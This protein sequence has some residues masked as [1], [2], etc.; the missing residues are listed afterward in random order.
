MARRLWSVFQEFLAT[1]IG[2]FFS[3]DEAEGMPR[4][5][6]LRY[7]G[8]LQTIALLTIIALLIWPLAA[9]HPPA[10]PAVEGLLL[11]V[12]AYVVLYALIPRLQA[13]PHRTLIHV[14]LA[15]LAIFGLHFALLRVGYGL[16]ARDPHA[17][18]LA[19]LVPL[20]MISRHGQTR[21]W[22]LTLILVVVLFLAF[23]F[24]AAGADLDQP[25][26]NPFAYA[27]LW[28]ELPL[29]ITYRQLLLITLFAAVYHA[30]VREMHHYQNRIAIEYEMTDLLTAQPAFSATFQ[31]AVNAI[32]NLRRPASDYAF[33]LLRHGQTDQLKVVGVAGLPLQGW[34][35][36]ALQ[37]GT[38]ITG[39]AL[40][41]GRTIR[42]GDVHHDDYREIFFGPGPL[43]HVRS[44]MATP[45]IVNGH[46]IGV[47]DVESLRPNAYTLQHAAKL[48][49]WAK[50]MANTYKHFHAID[51]QVAAANRLF[52]RIIQL[53]HEYSRRPT[54]GGRVSYRAWF[55]AV[56][57]EIAAHFHAD[58]AALLRLG[59]GT[60]HPLPPP[61]F[62]SRGELPPLP[63]ALRR[64]DAISPAGLIAGLIDEWQIRAWCTHD[65]WAEWRAAD[66]HWLADILLHSGVSTLTFV[67]IGPAGDR[68]AMLFLAYR[69]P[70][71]LNDVGRLTLQG[72]RAAL[73]TSYRAIT[74]WTSD[75]HHAG[76]RVHQN[77]ITRTQGAFARVDVVRHALR[78]LPADPPTATAIE[79]TLDDIS[80]DLRR[81]RQ[82]IKRATLEERFDL[83][84]T[85]LKLALKSTADDYQDID[86]ERLKIPV[87]VDDA[88]ETQSLFVRQLLYWIAVEAIANAIEHGRANAITVNLRA[89]PDHLRLTVSDDGIGLPPNPN[90]NQPHG[91]YYLKRLA[92]DVAH[93]S[94][95]LLPN[96]PRGVR[97][98][99]RLP[100]R[101]EIP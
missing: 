24:V 66:E 46:P 83:S 98:E 38:G 91:I 11:L 76:I 22:T 26:P 65:E 96:E 97:I 70:E 2:I 94:L 4:A 25:P 34:Q 69:H 29:L 92:Y 47:L 68:Q 48:E 31:A 32:L 60:A 56:A 3:G 81:L 37:P 87:H 80:A 41:E 71:L 89:T 95:R 73:E 72:L 64:H 21:Y 74:P 61:V 52:E 57:A 23:R 17:L 33:V 49:A 67:P 85:S 99:L 5:F 77:V 58:Y 14:A 15:L 101:R 78:R 28:R 50:T 51:R 54:P 20:I 35:E 90:R 88:V 19:T 84:E 42:A 7:S 18:W 59:M 100:I 55:R 53:G 45:I 40:A 10:R 6:I 79:A 86:P 82:Q 27:A 13:L 44:E 62:W 1:S 43:A 30:G 8:N 12:F 39:Q 75:L 93:A 63:A 36:L 9:A 16:G